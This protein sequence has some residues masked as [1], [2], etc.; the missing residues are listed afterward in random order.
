MYSTF[1]SKKISAIELISVFYFSLKITIVY[2]RK[3]KL[4]CPHLLVIG[5]HNKSIFIELHQWK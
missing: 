5:L 2:P 3:I 1:K 4:Y